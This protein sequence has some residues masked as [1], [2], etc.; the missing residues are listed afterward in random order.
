MSLIM[1]FRFLTA[2]PLPGKATPSPEAFGKATR[3]FPLV[4]LILGLILAGFSLLFR[5]FLPLSLSA[6]L[7]VI[8][9]V[10]LTGGLH[11][12][13]LAD[14]SDGLG[15]HRSPEQRRQVM[16]DSRN[17][18]FGIAA[19][20]LVLLFKY[21]ALV[22]LP[23]PLLAPA[24]LYMTVMGRWSMVFSIFSFNYAHTE[25]LGSAFKL[26]TGRFNFIFATLITL[27]LVA[28]MAPLSG[29]GSIVIWPLTC[30]VVTIAALY[31]KAKF[32]GLTGDNYGAINEIAEI[33][34]LLFFIV[35]AGLNII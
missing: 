10:L 32:A 34:V 14:T 29:L 30:L 22:S 3:Y 35:L 18:A 1:A 9:S 28:G 6:V 2:I 25:G 31:Y 23:T 16:R 21:V 15:G 12:D 4:G 19:V 27:L 24:L 7:I 5:I 33:F 17:G 26:G 8:S 11:L 20:V 13:G